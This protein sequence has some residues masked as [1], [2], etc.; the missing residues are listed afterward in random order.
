MTLSAITWPW[1]AHVFFSETSVAARLQKSGRV[2]KSPSFTAVLWNATTQTWQT[3]KSGQARKGRGQCKGQKPTLRRVLDKVEFVKDSDGCT[4][5]YLKHFLTAVGLPGDNAHTRARSF[6][7]QLRARGVSG[8]VEQKAVPGRSGK[9][10]FL[11]SKKVL[12]RLYD[13]V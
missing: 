11:A 6:N 8:R 13:F 4:K 10:P 5:G 2:W 7:K 12:R 3:L 9:R 1:H